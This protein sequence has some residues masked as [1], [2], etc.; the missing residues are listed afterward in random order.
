LAD[1]EFD[2]DLMALVAG[3]RTLARPVIW[4]GSAGLATHLATSLA[5]SG[6]CRGTGN[7]PWVLGTGLQPK[8]NV[9]HGDE[10]VGPWAEG[11]LGE[12]G[13]L[14][15][16]ATREPIG[17][18]QIAALVASE[19]AVVTELGVDR[20]EMSVWLNCE[21]PYLR[22][23]LAEGGV[24]VVCSPPADPRRA[25]RAECARLVV[26]LADALMTAAPPVDLVA[27]GGETAR[28]LLDALGER[29][30]RILREVE[31][32]VPQLFTERRGLGLVTKAGSFGTE[33]SLV[34]AVAA[35]RAWRA[36][37][38]ENRQSPK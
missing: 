21:L 4:V 1:A 3:G 31:L 16:V 34:K 15:L 30:C 36:E 2:S 8:A 17:R 24:V 19:N 6:A 9:D 35:L 32:G 26:Q 33:K 7:L 11:F 14:V 12:R 20:S 18:T 37:E 27:T 10:E 28:V 38:L 23:R 29:C 13:V 25:E 5:A 22:E